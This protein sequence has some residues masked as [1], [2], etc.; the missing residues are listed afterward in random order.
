MSDGI[1]A[2]IY[3]RMMPPGMEWP[4]FEDGERVEFGSAVD[5]LDAPCEKF[6]FTRSMGGVCQLQDAGGNMVN[7]LNG[8]RVKRPEPEVLGADGLPI[9]K[10]T[11]GAE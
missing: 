9:A 11:G 2:E 8:E 1:K 7:V 10:T 3:R 5:G 6:I 4:R